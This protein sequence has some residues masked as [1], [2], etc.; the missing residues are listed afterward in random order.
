M[1]QAIE[2]QA[3]E[4]ANRPFYASIAF[5]L[6]YPWIPLTIGLLLVIGV[7]IYTTRT[8]QVAQ[9]YEQRVSE[10]LV[11]IGF[12]DGVMLSL[13]EMNAAQR[14][15]ILSG[16][17]AFGDRYRHSRDAFES[18]IASLREL[19]DE[20]GVGIDGMQ[21]LE[22][23]LKERFE[24]FA[25]T[26]QLIESGDLDAAGR[27]S[28]S[29]REEMADVAE[30]LAAIKT[31][32]FAR[33]ASSQATAN[34]SGARA[35]VLN[36]AGLTIAALL[37]L[38]SILL[39]T[40]RSADLERA[41]NEVRA[42]ADTLELRVAE[43]TTDLEEANEEIQRFAYIVSHDLRSPLVNIMGFT[44]ELEEAQQA[45][46]TYLAGDND[47]AAPEVPEEV[48]LAV[49]EDMPESMGFISSST[50]RMDRLIKAILQI[51][52]E[53]RRTMSKEDIAL[54][55]LFADLRESLSGQLEAADAELTLLPLPEVEA[56][57]LALEQIFGNLLD[58]AV[59]Y[60]R[61]G[62][63]GRI[64]VS[65]EVR[66]RRAIIRITDNG[67]GVAE[68]DRQ[69]IFELFRRAGEQDQPGE[70]IG[71][72]HVQALVRGLGGK[73]ALESVLGEGSCFSVTL[74]LSKA[75]R[76]ISK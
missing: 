73:I 36:V 35:L 30:A 31:D 41:N 72:A 44:A 74:P 50:G 42:F 22:V 47:D 45:V 25:E 69:R 55:V 3:D 58:N 24:G 9:E 75:A 6:T 23:A 20:T 16:D 7:G 26:D 32:A 54:D 57:R 63:P 70:G 27:S 51:S 67:R 33:V 68:S 76:A 12:A 2:S 38:L 29:E 60:L 65:G 10:Y 62:V 1:N 39:L 61:P 34:E 56:D 64:D 48:R 59:K 18:D 43:R 40:R 49:L 71:L 66:G 46:A 5:I 37:I 17:P 11:T 13:E 21:T 8:V 14:G 15:L 53:G 19:V 52:R 4:D 28:I